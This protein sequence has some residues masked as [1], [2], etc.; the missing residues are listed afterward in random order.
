MIERFASVQDMIF[1]AIVIGMALKLY[2]FVRE[3]W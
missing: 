2:Q 3:D 1:L